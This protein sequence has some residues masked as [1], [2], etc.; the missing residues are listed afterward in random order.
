METVVI[1]PTVEG[2]EKRIFANRPIAIYWL[3]NNYDLVEF[4]KV[5]DTREYKTHDGYTIQVKP[6]K[7]HELFPSINF[8]DGYILNNE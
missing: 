1:Y 2:V 4:K 7:W 3:E 6:A 8:N 5:D